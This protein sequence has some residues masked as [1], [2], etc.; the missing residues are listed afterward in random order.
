MTLP[1]G[2][3]GRLPSHGGNHMSSG[4][5]KGSLRQYKVGTIKGPPSSDL[6]SLKQ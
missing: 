4:R 5:E 2:S 1:K 3:M 6:K